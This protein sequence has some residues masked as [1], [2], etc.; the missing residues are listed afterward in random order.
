MVDGTVDSKYNKEEKTREV[1]DSR[2]YHISPL[3]LG[4]Q[5][6]EE[7]VYICYF[8]DG[9]D[10]HCAHCLEQVARCCQYRGLPASLP[11]RALQY[12][13]PIFLS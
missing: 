7:I 12:A 6:L 4:L 3:P 8:V 1:A 13:N 2:V 9:D 10:A 11:G 5:S